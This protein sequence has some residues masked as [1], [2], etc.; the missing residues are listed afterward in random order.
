MYPYVDETRDTW[1]NIALCLKEFPRAK[2]EGT[3][4]DKELYLNVYPKSSPN[5]GII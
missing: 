2:P 5:T 3:S 4:V 1:S